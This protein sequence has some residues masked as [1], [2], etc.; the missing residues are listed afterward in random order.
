MVRVAFK[1]MVFLVSQARSGLAGD[2]GLTLYLV[3]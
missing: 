1:I 3:F 2:R